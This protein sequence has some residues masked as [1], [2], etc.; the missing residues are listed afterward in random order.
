VETSQ[1]L[2]ESEEKRLKQN[3]AL[4]RELGAESDASTGERAK[5]YAPLIQSNL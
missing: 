4:A 1:P 3:M 2:N 5:R